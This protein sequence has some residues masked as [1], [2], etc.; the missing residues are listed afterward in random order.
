LRYVKPFV[1]A[2]EPRLLLDGARL[3]TDFTGNGQWGDIHNWA[4]ESVP[5]DHEIAV[6]DPKANVK[7]YDPKSTATASENAALLTSNVTLLGLKIQNWDYD[8]T[9]IK[10]GTKVLKIRASA[11]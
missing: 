8:K 5:G 7:E 11:H 1:E 2:L 10:Q 9:T 4:P 6:F 3:W